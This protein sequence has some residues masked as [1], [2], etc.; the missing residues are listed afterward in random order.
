MD[1]YLSLKP[2]EV[3]AIAHKPKSMIKRCSFLACENNPFCNDLQNF[4]GVSFI[5]PT[6]GVCYMFNFGPYYALS[7]ADLNSATAN[8][9][10]G[11]I[12]EIDIE[13]KYLIGPF[14]TGLKTGLLKWRYF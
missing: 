13:S 10:Y 8:V 5:T 7:G 1:S 2:A 9:I 6:Y 14:H 3:V 12:L 4:G 11:L